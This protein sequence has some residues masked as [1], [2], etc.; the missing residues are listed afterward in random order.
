L[1]R[2]DAVVDHAL[3]RDVVIL[4]KIPSY[5]FGAALAERAVFRLRAVRRRVAGH[6]NEVTLLVL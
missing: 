4:G 6:L 3:E 2:A 5:G 1:V